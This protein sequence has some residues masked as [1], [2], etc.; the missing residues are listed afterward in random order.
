MLVEAASNGLLNLLNAV[1]SA[2][3]HGATVVSMSWGGGEFSTESSYDYHF[4]N[5]GVAYVASSGDS[6]G[7]V[8][9]PA[10][11]P[12]VLSVAGTTLST[13]SS[14]NYQGETG[15]SGGGGTS[16]C[17][18]QPGYQSSLGFAGR[19]TPDIAYDANSNS[20]VAVYDSV[21]YNRQSGWFEVGATSVGAPQWA[22]LIAVADYNRAQ[23]H[24]SLLDTDYGAAGSAP[25]TSILYNSIAYG[26]NFHDITSGTA[27]SNSAGPGYDQV[28]GIGSPI[29]SQLLNSLAN[30]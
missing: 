6:G 20:G 9:W 18:S 13:D 30:G 27:G 24:K 1:D 14:G 15:W 8:E 3:S 28:T 29:A 5:L 25:A 10:A 26:T 11:S 16:S 7:G 22:A 4:Q 12:Y 23:A 17:E 19:S 21:T 2:T